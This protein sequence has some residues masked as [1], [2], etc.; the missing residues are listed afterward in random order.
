ME[1]IFL[2][3]HLI[4]LTPY[5]VRLYRQS[6]L[7]FICDPISTNLVPKHFTTCMFYIEYFNLISTITTIPWIEGNPWTFLNTKDSPNPY[8]ITLFPLNFPYNNNIHIF[9]N[10][11][12]ILQFYKFHPS[13]YPNFTKKNIKVKNR[14]FKLWTSL[15]ICGFCSPHMLI[16]WCIS[17]KFKWSF[18]N[19]FPIWLNQLSNNLFLVSIDIIIFI[20]FNVWFKVMLSKSLSQS[21]TNVYACQHNETTTQHHNKTHNKV[22]STTRPRENDIHIQNWI[23]TALVIRIREITKI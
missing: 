10:T 22:I 8:L 1:K 19:I 20:T 4:C 15:I 13:F 7:Q 3:H 9:H 17:N 14:K 6:L 5:K 23:I 18:I 16:I 2:L 11:L 21:F 12:K